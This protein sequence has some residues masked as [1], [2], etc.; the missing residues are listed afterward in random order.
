MPIDGSDE[1]KTLRD[2][3]MQRFERIHDTMKYGLGAFIALLAYY[4][5]GAATLDDGIALSLFQ[6]LD[7]KSVV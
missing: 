6:L 1:Y 2:E 4:H 5:S 7:R 3:M